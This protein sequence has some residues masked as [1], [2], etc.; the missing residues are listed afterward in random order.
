MSLHLHVARIASPIVVNTRQL[1]VTVHLD[2]YL[3]L[4]LKNLKKENRI[5]ES[6]TD[7]H[8][9]TTCDDKNNGDNKHH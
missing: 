6:D 1:S 8:L 9:S 3:K 5:V 2:A 7:E 4:S